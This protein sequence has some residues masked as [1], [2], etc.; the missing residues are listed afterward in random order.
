MRGVFEEIY[1]LVRRVPKGKVSSYGD[2]A[3]MCRRDV[4]ARTVGW[5]MSDAPP[6]VPWHRIVNS[7]GRLTI[8]RRSVALMDLQRSLLEAEGVTFVRFDQAII[9]K[10]RWIPTHLSALQKKA[11]PREHGGAKPKLGASRKMSVR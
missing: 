6:D 8:G 5:A 7:R 10:H 3:S 1:R 9:E 11:T 2:I 4:S